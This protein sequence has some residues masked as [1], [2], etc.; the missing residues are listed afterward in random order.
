M[1]VNDLIGQKFTRLTVSERIGSDSRGRSI[2]LCMCDCGNKVVARS[3]SLKSG[4]TKSCGCYHRDNVSK[5]TSK[6]GKSKTKLYGVWGSMKDRCRNRN[7]KRFLDY[8]GRGISV[9]EDWQQD[10]ESFYSWAMAAGYTA[11]MTLDRIDVNAGYCP[12]NCRWISNDE[13]QKNK[14]NNRSILFDGYQYTISEL[15]LKLGVSRSTI[16]RKYAS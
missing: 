10:Y 15:A 9:C 13:Q 2:W 1:I 11:G 14:R 3:D 16:L 4:A 5:F 7:H 6:H 12:S 8:G